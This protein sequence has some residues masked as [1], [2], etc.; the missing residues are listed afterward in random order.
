M[1]CW[2]MDHTESPQGG[3]GPPSSSEED[4]VW[5]IVVFVVVAVV[6]RWTSRDAWDRIRDSKDMEGPV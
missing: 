4:R 2:K 3:G 5:V 6:V 1:P